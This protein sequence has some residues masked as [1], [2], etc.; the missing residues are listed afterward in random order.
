M[1]RRFLFFSLLFFLFSCGDKAPKDLLSMQQMQDIKWDL[2]RA[3]EMV[4][5]YR[6]ADTAYPAEQKR[7]Q[8]YDIIFNIH[9]TSKE[10]FRRSLDYYTAR[11]KELKKILDAVQAK[12]NQQANADTAKATK[13]TVLLN[14]DSAKIPR[15]IDSLKR[16]KLLKI[17]R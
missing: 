15:V 17:G 11:P 3:D 4:D 16:K 1:M 5:Y 2:M 12:A 7:E 10:N 14:K 13:D 8:Y 9:H 6:A